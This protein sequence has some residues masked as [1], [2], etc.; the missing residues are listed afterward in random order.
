MLAYQNFNEQFKIHMDAS[1]HYQLGEVI[2]QK[3]KPTAFY[4]WKLNP[5][6]ETMYTTTERE[7][8]NIVETLKEYYNILLGQQI[9]VFMDHKNLVNATFNTEHI[10]RWHLIIKEFGPKLSYIKGVNNTA[11]PVKSV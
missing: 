3:G 5:A 4:S 2:S 11:R 6:Q 8:L 10:R 1:N 9:E 7:L